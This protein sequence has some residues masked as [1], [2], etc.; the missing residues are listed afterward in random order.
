MINIGYACLTLGVPKADFRSCILKNADDERL[1]ELIAHNLNSLENI[2]D[3]NIRNQIRL[4]R[5]SSGLIPFGSSPVNKLPWW[6]LFDTQLSV[7]GAKLK[8]GNVRVSMHPGQ[9]TVLNSPDDS[10]VERAALDLIYHA[11]VLD[12]LGT[13]AESKIILHI[14]GI[15]SDKARALK[16]FEENYANLDPSVKR[17]V[18]IENDDKA[19][20]ITD[21]LQIGAKLDIPVV[22]DNLH[23]RINPP[24]TQ[25][26]VKNEGEDFIDENHWIGEAAKTWKPEDGRQKIHYSQQDPGRRPGSHSVT[27]YTDE[28]LEFYN[29]IKTSDIDVMLEVKDKNLS[30][31]KCNNLIFFYG[32]NSHIPPLK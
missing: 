24:E 18:V 3:Y 2:I 14:G 11:K 10:I 19:Y 21:A 26:P 15:Y 8:E 22:F 32:R 17:R 13:N 28:F 16:R 27:I 20:T 29:G 4:F 12:A 6:D 1:I 30:A 7:I 25:T 31:V 5:I 9:Y 23:H